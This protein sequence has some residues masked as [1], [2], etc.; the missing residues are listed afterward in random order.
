MAANRSL[1]NFIF[2][3]DATTTGSKDYMVTSDASQMMLKIETTGT[4]SLKL[5][6]DN[7]PKSSGSLKPYACYQ[8]PTMTSITGNI[9][10]AGYLYSIDLTSIDYL[11]V[12]IVSL[13]G[14]LSVYGKVVG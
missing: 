10:D 5:T 11:R 7:S 14:L 4:F 8:I 13:T 12:E 2:F 3:K 6:A 1:D 9:T